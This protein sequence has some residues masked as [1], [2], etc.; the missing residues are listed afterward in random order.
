MHGYY[1]AG[2]E[3]GYL[4]P[5]DGLYDDPTYDSW[6]SHSQLAELAASIPCK[7]VLVALDACYSGIFGEGRERP[8]ASAWE[9]SGD[10]CAQKIATAFGSAEKARKYVTAGG[11]TR[12]P[13]KSVFV[14][15]W[16]KALLP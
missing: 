14:Q 4:I 3:K 8:V 1:D 15:Q 6:Y 7:R 5:K 10:D 12:V 11:N 9:A 13:A 2:S 16:H